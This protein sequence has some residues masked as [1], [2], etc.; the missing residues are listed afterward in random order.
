MTTA[1]LVLAAGASTRL[2]QPKQ[3]VR[4]RGE[5]LLERA[6]RVAGVAGLAPVVVVLGASAARISEGCD[7]RAAWVVV[8]PRWSEGMGSSVRAGMELVE[9]FGEVD[10]VVLM[11]CDMP[12]VEAGHLRALVDACEEVVGSGYAGREGVPAYF[13]RRRFGELKRLVGDAGAR[14]LLRGTRTV[15][16]AE[17]EAWDVDTPE[18]AQQLREGEAG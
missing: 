14:A 17:D 2:G 6:V 12:R 13:A 5:T 10:G 11:T 8:N 3:T 1:A 18:D 7:L 15:P 16:L 4:W 9:G